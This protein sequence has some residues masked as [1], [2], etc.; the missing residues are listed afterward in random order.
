[1]TGGE[2]ALPDGSHFQPDWLSLREPVDHRSRPVDLLEPLAE[3]WRGRGWRRVLDLGSG[4]GSNV[5]YL[6]PRL[7][8]PQS[9]TLVDHDAGLLA[10]AVCPPEAGPVERVEG[11]L[12]EEGID[13]VAA[14]DLV[15][16]SALLDLV[17][18]PWLRRLVEACARAGAGVLFATSYDG[19]ISWE[20]EDPATGRADDPGHHPDDDWLRDLVNAH[21]RRDKGTGGAL[22]PSAAHVAR[23]RFREAGYRTWMLPGPW[24]L[25]AGD[26]DL[27]A[28]LIEG[29]AE[30]ARE[31]SPGDAARIDAWAASALERSASGRARL[32]VG[33]QDLL[34]LPGPD[35][36]GG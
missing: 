22:G 31:Q 4:T 14:H 25:D 18:E 1:M 10:R 12:G 11:D 32:Q 17:S 6:A 13:L 19:S 15:T 26:A 33:H 2:E 28:R 36:P 35:G 23:E 30:A 20:A 7:P 24:V 34:A 9:W 8:E 16:A 27:A 29:W 5:R 21:Q 3:A